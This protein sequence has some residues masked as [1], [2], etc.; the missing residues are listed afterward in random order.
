MQ[1]ETKLFHVSLKTISK[2][3]HKHEYEYRMSRKKRL[4]SDKDKKLRLQYAF[5][6]RTLPVRFWRDTISFYFDVVGF[7]LQRNHMQKQEQC[8]P[9]PGGS[10]AKD[11]KKQQKEER[12]EAVK[13]W[14]IIL[15]QSHML[16]M[17]YVVNNTNTG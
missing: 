9:W 6:K 8:H 14:Q 10:P 11:L 17:W 7:A 3:L 5:D 4:L 1:E 15:W 12:K 13:E 2:V 16:M